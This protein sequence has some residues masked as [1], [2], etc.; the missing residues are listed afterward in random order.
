MGLKKHK[1]MRAK[2]LSKL[3]D[4]FLRT[5]QATVVGDYAVIEG[6]E[7]GPIMQH[8]TADVDPFVNMN[9]IG[10]INLQVEYHKPTASFT[11]IATGSDEGAVAKV[12][13]NLKALLDK[14]YGGVV[15]QA[16][17]HLQTD[18]F[19]KNFTFDSGL[20]SGGS[21]KLLEINK[22]SHIDPF[23]RQYLETALW[24]STDEGGE[25]LDAN[26]T[27]NDFSPEA[28]EACIKDCKAFQ[29]LHPESKGN[30]QYGHDFWL[31]RNRH[32]AGFWD[33]DYPQSEAAKLTESAHSF[34]SVDLM[35]GDDGMI[36]IL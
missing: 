6:F 32:G 30:A 1:D 22:S 11:V 20:S 17:S 28:L 18:S 27:I 33:G 8:I 24:A 36:H 3:A 10:S 21:R 25:P 29:I 26:F 34:G 31:T 16:L 4:S 19:H 9:G 5:A 23:L 15:A 14:K 13:A 12:N 7:K 35:V 2:Q